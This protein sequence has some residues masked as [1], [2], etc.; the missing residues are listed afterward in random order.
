MLPSPAAG[1][2]LY[3]ANAARLSAFYSALIGFRVLHADEEYVLL[4]FEAFELVVLTTAES[5]AA[6]AAVTQPPTR[7]TKAAFKPVF[8]VSSIA[9]ARALAGELGGN[10]NPSTDEWRFQDFVVCDGVDPEGNVFQLRQR[11][12]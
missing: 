2:V 5:R 8:F 1:A 10:L 6:G 12:E 7:R 3:A 11:A 9:S 4:R